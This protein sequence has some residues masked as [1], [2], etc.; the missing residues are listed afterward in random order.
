VGDG[1]GVVVFC[2]GELFGCCGLFLVWGFFFYGR[3]V[4][5]GG[6]GGGEGGRCCLSVLGGGFFLFFFGVFF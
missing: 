1:G 3:S 5:F 6:R 4:G 2:L